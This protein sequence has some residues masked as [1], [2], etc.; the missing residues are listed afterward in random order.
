VPLANSSVS[1]IPEDQKGD[2][3]ITAIEEVGLETLQAQTGQTT[4]S[5]PMS[6]RKMD[7]NFDKWYAL[8]RKI[9]QETTALQNHG[10]YVTAIITE[11]QM[12]QRLQL[13]N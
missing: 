13:F 11:K 10:I 6:V 1:A 12:Q 9:D 2:P 5:I 7:Q 3:K 8:G 4:R